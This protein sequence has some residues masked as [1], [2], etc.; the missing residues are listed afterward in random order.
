MPKHS[1]HKFLN[2]RRS[3]ASSYIIGTVCYHKAV[4]YVY[5][6]SHKN[7]LCQESFNY[8][9]FFNCMVN[10]NNVN[11]VDN[12]YLYGNYIAFEGNFTLNWCSVYDGEQLLIISLVQLL[13]VVFYA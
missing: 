10:T 6:M 1:F 3:L 5:R 11:N 13:G 9:L 4:S 2:Y 12:K 7:Q 8:R